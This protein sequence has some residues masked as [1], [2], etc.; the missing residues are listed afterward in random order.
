MDTF[1]FAHISDLH[2]SQDAN[3]LKP[4]IQTLSG[5][6]ERREASLETWINAH[7]YGL[8]RN[9]IEPPSH[10]SELAFELSNVL[11]NY[12]SYVDPFDFI[13]VTG[14]IATTGSVN[15]LTIGNEFLFGD[16]NHK[17]NQAVWRVGEYISPLSRLDVDIFLLPGNHDRYKSKRYLYFPANQNFDSIFSHAWSPKYNICGWYK[18]RKDS[19]EK[20]AIFLADFSFKSVSDGSYSYSEKYKG[21]IWGQGR[22]YQAMITYLQYVTRKAH[23]GGYAV[24]WATHFAPEFPDIDDKLKLLGD[25]Y[26]IRA[27]KEAGVE[28]IFCGHTHN[29]KSYLASSVGGVNVYCAA[30]A[31]EF[32]FPPSPNEN[33]FQVM[34]LVVNGRKIERVMQKE[35]MSDEYGSYN[36]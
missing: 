27:A 33:G 11:Y 10:S 6:E 15:D 17:N 20:L 34:K 18:D 14:D 22:V 35:I 32:V 31:T 21:G 1:C 7:Q 2:F 19:N 36:Q 13:L 9:L 23:E 5:G 26:I 16:A 25:A 4:L 8:K 30:S 12:H 24:I 29:Q 28:N 3:R